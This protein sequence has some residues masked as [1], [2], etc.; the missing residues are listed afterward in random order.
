MPRYYFSIANGQ[1]FDDIDGLELPDL[2]AVR[3][4][5]AGFARDLMRLETERRDWSHWSVRVTDDNQNTV[6][7]LPFLEAR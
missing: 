5:A 7:D 2:E 4:E 3:A 1:R 6:L